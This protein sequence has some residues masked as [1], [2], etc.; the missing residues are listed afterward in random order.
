MSWLPELE[1]CENDEVSGKSSQDGNRTLNETATV[2][3]HWETQSTVSGRSTD[4]NGS[5]QA[6]SVM[7]FNS[8]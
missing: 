8:L 4:V 1:G 2:I 7:L 5:L 3:L 6:N